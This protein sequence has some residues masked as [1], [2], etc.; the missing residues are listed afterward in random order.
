MPLEAVS[1]ESEN[2]FAQRT[3]GQEKCQPAVCEQSSHSQSQ[4]L[5]ALY[6]NW[7]IHACWAGAARGGNK[8]IAADPGRDPSGPTHRAPRGNIMRGAHARGV[9][10][11]GR[12]L[13]STRLVSQSRMRTR[14]FVFNLH[15]AR[16]HF[17]LQSNN[18]LSPAK[19][20]AANAHVNWHHWLRESRLVYSYKC[21]ACAI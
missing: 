16:I 11:L 10:C 12:L 13:N 7:L 17:H 5:R 2:A 4:G 6:D 19:V 20:K 9:V 1:N 8:R 18:M 15:F 14:P 3:H 21:A